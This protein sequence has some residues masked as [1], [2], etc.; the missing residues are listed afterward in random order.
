MTTHVLYEYKPFL[1]T[2]DFEEVEVLNSKTVVTYRVDNSELAITYLDGKYNTYHGKL[3]YLKLPFE[4]TVRKMIQDNGEVEI[5]HIYPLPPHLLLR[6]YWKKINVIDW[7][8]MACVCS[9]N[10]LTKNRIIFDMDGVYGGGSRKYWTN[11][12]CIDRYW[13]ILFIDGKVITPMPYPKGMNQFLGRFLEDK[14]ERFHSAIK[15]VYN[16]LYEQDRES[17]QKFLKKMYGK[18]FNIQV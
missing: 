3:D 12:Y 15:I 18:T 11:E 16:D 1:R 5:E 10:D 2:N 9:D 4:E 17:I 8:S 7:D 14:S 6:V 13:T